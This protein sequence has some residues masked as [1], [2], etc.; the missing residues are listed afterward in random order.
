MED[1]EGGVEDMS[2]RRHG[3]LEGQD[4]RHVRRLWKHQRFGSRGCKG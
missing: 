3:K 1:V 2:K 4:G